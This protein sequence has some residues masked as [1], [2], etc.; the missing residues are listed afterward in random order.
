MFSTR[1][2]FF[3]GDFGRRRQFLRSSVR[4][5]VP[6]ASNFAAFAELRQHVDHVHRNANR[7]GL[8]GNRTGDRLANPPRGIR[9]ELVAAAVFVLVNRAHQAG[10]PFLNQVE[11]RQAAVAIFFGDADHQ[12]QVAAATGCRLACS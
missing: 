2:G 3:D 1:C 4:G 10:V 6:V 9:A 7:A 11:E 12:P 5:A 8:V